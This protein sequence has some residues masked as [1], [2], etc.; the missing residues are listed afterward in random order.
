MKKKSKR[1]CSFSFFETSDHYVRIKYVVP[2]SLHT[3]S[4][5]N[6]ENGVVRATVIVKDINSE[7][8][9]RQ[10]ENSWKTS[11]IIPVRL[12]PDYPLSAYPIVQ[13]D[14][15]ISNSWSLPKWHVACFSMIWCYLISACIA[16]DVDVDGPPEDL[17]T[18]VVV[19]I[20][21]PVLLLPG[22]SILR[23]IEHDQFISVLYEP[24]SSSK[25]L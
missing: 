8:L 25:I 24:K 21:G 5:E 3:S 14:R 10:C 19:V 20:T 11:T 23:Q 4:S 1:S 17:Y 6:R 9:Y 18:A 13:L 15:D 7:D 12:D 2:S 16:L 22:A